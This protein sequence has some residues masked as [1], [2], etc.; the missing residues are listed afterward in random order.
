M[1]TLRPWTSNLITPIIAA[2]SRLDG[3]LLRSSHVAVLAE[4]PQIVWD[5]RPI[6]EDMVHLI[7]PSA[8]EHAKT[9][10][11]LKDRAPDLLPVLRKLLTAPRLP[12][13]RQQHA[14]ATTRQ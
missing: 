12:T 5:V 4:A 7:R 2:L 3:L 8:T 13:P 14:P 6:R 9:A 10:V 1:F 11:T